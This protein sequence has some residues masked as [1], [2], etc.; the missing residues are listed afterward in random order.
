MWDD[1]LKVQVT[2]T[3][4][5]LRSDETPLPD[6][7][8][9]ECFEILKR[10]HDGWLERI[11]TFVE[12]SLGN[13]KGS[14]ASPNNNPFTRNTYSEREWCDIL[15]GFEDY[16]HDFL[17]VMKDGGRS[18]GLYLVS[19]FSPE[20]MMAD[21]LYLTMRIFTPREPKTPLSVEIRVYSMLDINSIYFISA[22]VEYELLTMSILEEVEFFHEAVKN[23]IESEAKVSISTNPQFMNKMRDYFE[24][25]G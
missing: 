9:D 8:D 3:R 21:G 5:Q 7:D 14:V 16:E 17:D 20:K 13:T 25:Y 23:I 2:T 4:Q 15:E 18:H 19:R 6:D 22:D 10:I 11:G 24:R 12:N 1:I